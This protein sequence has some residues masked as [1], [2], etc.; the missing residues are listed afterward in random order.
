[1]RKINM[2][3]FQKKLKTLIAINKT[4]QVFQELFHRIKNPNVIDFENEITVLS[5]QFNEVTRNYALGMISPSQH[6]ISKAKINYSL[7]KIIDEID[8]KKGMYNDIAPLLDVE[9][10]LNNPLNMVLNETPSI[11]YNYHLEEF[12]GSGG[13][14]TVFKAKHKRLETTVAIKISYPIRDDF[15]LAKVLDESINKQKHLIHN[16]ILRIHDIGEIKISGSNRIFLIM[17]FIEGENLREFLFKNKTESRN[18]TPQKLE[19]YRTICQTIDYCHSL[20]YYHEIGYKI[21]GIFHGDIKP[22]NILLTK[23]LIPKISDFMFLDFREAYKKMDEKQAFLKFGVN[24]ASGILGTYGYM[25]PEQETGIISDKTDIYTLGI[26]LLEMFTEL[27]FNAEK[28]LDFSSTED[29]EKLFTTENVPHSVSEIIFKTTQIDPENR[30][31]SVK[32][33]IEILD[34][35]SASNLG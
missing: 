30:L 1:M 17:E 15:Q 2:N 32:K 34:K 35:D 3:R 22:T 11:L 7:L 27:N 8:K 24:G 29:I 25:P 12:L 6:S 13:F 20:E 14:G 16:N 21:K 33:I 31:P 28:N 26:L 10:E 9:Y 23:E 5:G 18:I 4:E 19:I